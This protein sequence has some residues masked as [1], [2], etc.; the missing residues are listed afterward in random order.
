MCGGAMK[1]SLIILSVVVVLI[2]LFFIA[3]PRLEDELE[4]V[5]QAAT[6][7]TPYIYAVLSDMAYSPNE[8]TKIPTGWKEFLRSNLNPTDDN[9]DGNG[10]FGVAYINDATK[11]IV[12]AHRGTN[13]P[14]D[15]DDD[16]EIYIRRFP[17]QVTK[18]ALPFVQHI[19]REMER[20]QLTDYEVSQ[21]GHSLGGF[22]AELIAVPDSLPQN[23]SNAITRTIHLPTTQAVTFDS[24]GSGVF[25]R[26]GGKITTYLGPPNMINTAGAHVGAVIL[27]DSDWKVFRDC[28]YPPPPTNFDQ[29]VAFPVTVLTHYKDYSFAAHHLERL[30]S[31]FDA[32]TGEP[33][34]GLTIKANWPLG[35]LA[36]I[37]YFTQP[38]DLQFVGTD[39]ENIADNLRRKIE[40]KLLLDSST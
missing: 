40:C 9:D 25:I 15:W 11:Q 32:S 37:A 30:I 33:K 2:L 1:K 24:P 21:T 34:H 10:Y 8:T 3:V 39:D 14:D 13:S 23:I 19:Y 6:G 31:L 27:L 5:A 17:D 35:V 38:L 18:S 26:F 7:T 12:I 16:I 28:F 20:Q 4:Q 29:A 36:G 22:L